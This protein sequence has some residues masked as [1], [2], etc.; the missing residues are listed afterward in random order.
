MDSAWHWP[1]VELPV[2]ALLAKHLQR[3]NLTLKNREQD[4]KNVRKVEDIHATVLNALGIDFQQELDTP[5]GRPMIISKGQV[6]KE[7]L[8]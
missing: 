2:A 8:V 7:L 5:V 3:R 4:L 1:V 6:I